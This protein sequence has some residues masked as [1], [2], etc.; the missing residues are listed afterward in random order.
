MSVK[1]KFVCPASDTGVRRSRSFAGFSTAHERRMQCYSVSR[2]SVRSKL[3]S[4]K[5]SKIS[6][7]PQKGPN[8]LK[9]DPQQVEKIFRTL[10]KGLNEYLE[11][12]Q[13]ELDFLTAQQKDVKRNSRLAFLY[14]LDKVEELYESYCIQWRLRD[15]AHNMKLAYSISPST[16]AS[17]ESLIELHKNFKECTEDMRMIEGALE[18][19]LGQFHIRMKGLVG[20][21]RLCP[22]DQYEVFIRLGR[23]RWKLK[24]KIEADDRQ[25]WDEEKMTFLP[26]LHE[27]FEIKVTE[28]RGLT[29]ILVGAVVCNSVNFFMASPQTIVVDI[30]ELGTIKLQLE[31]IWDPFD[32]KE[33][34]VSGM[35]NRFSI[36]SR[37]VYN[38]TPPNTPSFREKYYISVLKHYSDPEDTLPF[39]A[40]DSK[41]TSIMS[42]LANRN[43]ELD[44]QTDG[45][46]KVATAEGT[47]R[48]PDNYIAS[49]NVRIQAARSETVSTYERKQ[50]DAIHP[51]KCETPDILREN[52]IN[53]GSHKTPEPDS[54]SNTIERNLM[55]SLSIQ[56]NSTDC[57]RPIVNSGHNVRGKKAT[58][59]RELLQEIIEKLKTQDLGCKELQQLEYQVLYN[60]N[61]LKVSN[62]K[63]SSMESLTV[64]TVLESFDFL[65]TD[66]TADELSCF[67]SMR[68]QDMNISTFHEGTLRQLGL[69]APNMVAEL[70]KLQNLPLT[71]GNESLDLTLMCHLQ[72]CKALL[73][74]LSTTNS[75][76]YIQNLL[77]EQLSLQAEVL[78]KISSI[79]LQ[80]G[81]VTAA[82]EVIHNPQKVKSLLKFWNECTESGTVFYCSTERLLNQLKR[83]FVHKIKGKYPGQLEIVF[84]RFVEQIINCSGLL[85]FLSLSDEWI[86][87]FQ[88]FNYLSK[89][90]YVLEE[91]LAK[92]NKEVSLT[93]MLQTPKRLKALKKLKRKQVSELQPLTST[94][95]LLALLQLDENYKVV[96]AVTTCLSKAS[97]NKKFRGKAIIYYAEL[98]MDY[99]VQLQ[100]A[101][102]LALKHLKGVESI[103]LIASLCQSEVE[104]VRT[105]ARETTLSFGVKGRLA[106]EKMDK[107]C[108]ELQDSLCQ[109]ADAEITIF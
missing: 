92:L 90:R 58:P 103:D 101:A 102:C 11:A 96:K 1:L 39:I 38:W 3:S 41:G 75:S 89:H 77:L 32:T 105:A 29:S 48:R 2:S 76:T 57:D 68:M 53:G 109:D 99:D 18:I 70:T 62:H 60:K 67:G 59:I 78:E 94:L 22:G 80:E 55:S 16:K 46:E 30:T 6:P 33:S 85:S 24:G 69:L 91:H 54:Y 13:M 61:I 37:K 20:F 44:L 106:F 25:T 79:S 23:Q 104:N 88:F 21:A 19:H 51:T 73:E 84:R 63:D 108:R 14:D 27:N 31:V 4:V 36:G 43:Y 52:G 7:P 81:T 71:T 42:Y 82:A 93:E 34:A 83:G 10:K 66:F 56:G 47:E 35:T 98:L 5:S 15:G 64:E 28:L 49:D 107:I 45:H 86:T 50:N 12:H 26:H 40:H 65:N 8:N 72:V 95:R 87:I 100:Q 74:Q 9:P 17:R 97:T